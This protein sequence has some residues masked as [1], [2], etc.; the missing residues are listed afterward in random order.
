MKEVLVKDVLTISDPVK[1]PKCG[2]VHKIST[3]NSESLDQVKDRR[4]ESYYEKYCLQNNFG[5]PKF[6]W[7]C[8]NRKC[9]EWVKGDELELLPIKISINLAEC[10]QMGYEFETFCKRCGKVHGGHVTSSFDTRGIHWYSV[11]CRYT[12]KLMKNFKAGRKEYD[13]SEKYDKKKRRRKLIECDALVGKTVKLA[14]WA[15]TYGRKN[16]EEVTLYAFRW[17]HQHAHP[18][19]S[20][21]KFN[22]LMNPGEDGEWISSDLLDYWTYFYKGMEGYIEK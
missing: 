18:E 13:W 5:D 10:W 16:N 15:S 9:N 1:C 6:L 14:S 21:K 2:W 11:Y 19:F 17:I 3:W 7:K 12:D 20:V 22:P 8:A 4:E